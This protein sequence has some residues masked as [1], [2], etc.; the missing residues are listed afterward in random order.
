M[1]S[2][3][4]SDTERSIAGRRRSR[5]RAAFGIFV[6]IEA[7]SLSTEQCWSGTMIDIN[8]DGMALSLPSELARG[9]E[10]LLTVC[11]G[12]DSQLTQVPAVVVR[13][14]EADGG[15][16]VEFKKWSD[17]DRLKLLGYLLEH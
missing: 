5:R 2:D 14:Q 15:G 16:A 7:P 8:G 4:T 10:V 17:P 6:A 3:H 11:L 12:R 9:T 1:R 13:S